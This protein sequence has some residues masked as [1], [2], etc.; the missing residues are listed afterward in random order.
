V[1]GG[2]FGALVCVYRGEGLQDGRG[3]LR[4]YAHDSLHYSTYRA[5]Q[6]HVAATGIAIVRTCYGINFR[7]PDGRTYS[8][9][10]E[11][12]CLSTRNLGII[13]ERA[14]DHEAQV[15]TRQA[16]DA[17]GMAAA[18]SPSC[19]AGSTG[20]TA[21]QPSGAYSRPAHTPGRISQPRVSGGRVSQARPLMS[22]R[23]VSRCPAGQAVS[24]FM[25]KI[26]FGL[27]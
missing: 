12:D 8:G 17:T 11:P 15:I 1:V 26:G 7:R 9:P 3:L 16:A 22:S 10:D 5:Y 2:R 27:W 6:W 25:C 24:V 20:T 4:A 23:V 13:M 19:H 18:R 21:R 14:T